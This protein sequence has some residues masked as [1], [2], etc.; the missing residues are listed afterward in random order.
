MNAKD[1]AALASRKSIMDARLD[2]K[3]QPYSDEPVI[4]HANV[5]YAVGSRVNAIPCGG[6]GLIHEMVRSL[7]LPETIDSTLQLFK[8]HKP[9]FESDHVLNIAYNVM[10]GG[11]CLE[12]IELLRNNVAYLDALGAH[13]VPDQTTAGDFLR[14]FE[15]EEHLHDLME[16]INVTRQRVWKRLPRRERKLALID[17]D[18]TIAPTLGECKQGMDITYKGKWG[19][20]PL[21]VTLANTQEVLYT[22]NR[23]GNRPSHEDAQVY[24]DAAVALVRDGGFK[25]A[26]L[27]GDTDFAITDHFDRWTYERVEF[28]LGVDAHPSFVA[29]AEEVSE[30]AWEPLLRPPSREPIKTEPRQRPT[31]V[32]QIIIEERGFKNLATESEHVTEMVYRPRKSERD[33]RMVVLRKTIRIMEGQLRLADEVRYLFYVTNVPRSELPAHEVVFQANARCHQENIIEQ[34]KNGVRALRMPSDSLLSN[35]A[36]L[37]IVSLAW[38]LKAWLSIVAPQS[39]MAREIRRMEFRRF[40]NSVMLIP[41]QVVKTGRRVVLRLLAWTSW[42]ELLLGGLAFFKRA[43]LT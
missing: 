4:G 14:R 11:T 13:R 15:S 35:G 22:K 21:V 29:R 23:P 25:K 39:K 28:V 43:R 18:G 38:N 42:A 10:C 6:I 16:A 9:Y 17:V 30:D 3:W 8:V 32:K 19:Y 33:Y 37:V 20:H 12:D 31:N 7:G 41:T 24:L 1:I 2:P 36:Y 34:L 27:R 5:S 26:R 40:L